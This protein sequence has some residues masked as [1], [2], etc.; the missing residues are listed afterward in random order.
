MGS[1]RVRTT[2]AAVVVVGLGLVMAGVALVTFVERSMRHDVQTAASNRAAAIADDLALG[3]GPALVTGG[4]RDEEFV[5]VLDT[6]GRVLI[7]SPNLSGRPALVRAQPGQ[8]RTIDTVPFE[9]G[10]FLAV[11]RGATVRGEPAVVVVGRDLQDVAATV[12]VV[13][14]SLAV[15]IPALL[16]LVWAVTWRVVG[17]ALA[18]V[19]SIRAEVEAIS[20]AELHRRVPAP[21][22]TDEITRLAA[23]MNH[24]LARLEEGQ[25]RQRRLVADASHELRSPVAAIRQHAEVALNHPARTQLPEFARVVLDEVLRLQRIVEDLLLLTKIDEGTLATGSSPVDLDDIVFD[26][27]ARLRG[28]GVLTVDATGVGAGRVLGDRRSL[29]RLVRNLV[30][31]ATRHARG[32]IALSLRRDDGEVVLAVDDD[33]RG[34]DAGDRERIFDRFVRLDDAR[35][36]D[37]GGSG[38][39][40][41]IVR[42]IAARHGATVVVRDSRLGGAG[43][44]LRLPVLED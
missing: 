21:P 23:T 41:S 37:G 36:R 1:I 27:A 2:A 34:I 30:D 3:A 5:Q 42:E 4:A 7:A 17:R 19:E 43:F 40:L 32:T 35:D 18:P 20:A 28:S 44:E 29:E 31:N 11:A 24:M 12:K 13:A 22:G 26:E 8:T 9:E 15:G 16:G 14:G 25:V 10:P 33:G 38:L 39:G 6:D